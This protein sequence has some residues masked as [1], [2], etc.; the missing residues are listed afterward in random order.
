MSN[1]S[2]GDFDIVKEGGAG[3]KRFRE[4]NNISLGAMADLSGLSEDTFRAVEAGEHEITMEIVGA[5]LGARFYSA[6]GELLGLS[7][8]QARQE[9]EAAE[10]KDILIGR[11]L[12]AIRE[13]HGTSLRQVAA[14]F[15][16][17]S[18][19][20]DK[21]ELGEIP[22]SKRMLAIC[23]ELLDEVAVAPSLPGEVCDFLV[24][25]RANI[26]RTSRLQLESET[27]AS[28]ETIKRLEDHGRYQSGDLAPYRQALLRFK[29]T[30]ARQKHLFPEDLVEF[31]KEHGVHL[32]NVGRFLGIT[33]SG[34]C[35]RETRPRRK[36]LTIKEVM[37]YLEA[38]YFQ[39]G[40]LS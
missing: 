11:I 22:L 24:F 3:F 15:G 38:A 9:C 14:R 8:P 36:P 27:G 20:L 33:E 6:I 34:V 19:A 1:F 5:Y 4:E 13:H 40:A 37:A 35:K 28:R 2:R 32:H 30:Q 26:L 21:I 18:V 25:I 12:R 17:S 39:E 29:R 7:P 10:D 23:L 31:R 16:V